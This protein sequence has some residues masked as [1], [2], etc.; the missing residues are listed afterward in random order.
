MRSF[1]AFEPPVYFSYV[2]YRPVFAE[3]LEEK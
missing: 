1:L 2:F 3:T